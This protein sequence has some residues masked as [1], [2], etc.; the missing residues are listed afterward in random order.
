MTEFMKFRRLLMFL[1][2]AITLSLFFFIDYSDLSF[3]NNK[4]EYSSIIS[5]IL[6]VLSM[7]MSNRHDA[8]KEKNRLSQN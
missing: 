2:L 7:I 3:R 6:L 4:T 1:M 8:K 5:G